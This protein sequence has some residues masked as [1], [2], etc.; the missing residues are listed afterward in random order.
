MISCK[1][2]PWSRAA[3]ALTQLYLILSDRVSVVGSV[4]ICAQA[5]AHRVCPPRRVSDLLLCGADAVVG[6]EGF[7][8]REVG[9]DAGG[10][11]GFVAIDARGDFKVEVE[12]L[13]KE[14]FAR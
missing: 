7:G 12:E 9:R 1:P 2:V 5:T 8:V 3:A 14:V 6:D 11:D 13:L 4:Q 10:G